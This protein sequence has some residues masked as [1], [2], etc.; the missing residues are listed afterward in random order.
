MGEFKRS[1][2]DFKRSIDIET[3]IQDPVPAPSK[4]VKDIIKDVNSEK[5]ET[6]KD[7]NDVHDTGEASDK[8]TDQ[9]K[10]ASNGKPA[11]S[12]PGQTEP[13]ND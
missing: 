1:A 11:A 6:Q 12:Q 5:E 9:T 2:Q 7:N 10:P 4:K 13:T 8:Q 3:T